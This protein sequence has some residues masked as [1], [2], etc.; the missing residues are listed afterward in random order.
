[1]TAL[2]EFNLFGERTPPPPPPKPSYAP[3][4]QAYALA[5]GKLD[6]TQRQALGQ[7]ARKLV[8]EGYPIEQVARA[9]GQL[10]RDG[11]FPAFLGRTLR[12]MPKPC[13]NGEARS[14]LTQQQLQSCSCESCKEWAELRAGRPLEL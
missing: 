8:G 6:K 5:G 11:N 9:A 2:P 1:M 3:V 13:T 14:R 4:Y 12:E 7:Q 10:G